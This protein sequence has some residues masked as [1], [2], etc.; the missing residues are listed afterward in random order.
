M[1]L[2]YYI[3]H[4]ISYVVD[5]NYLTKKSCF[6]IYIYWASIQCSE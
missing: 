6:Y 3:K 5:L 4:K 2:L 1:V